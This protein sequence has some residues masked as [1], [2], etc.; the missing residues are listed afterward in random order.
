MSARFYP[1]SQLV[2]STHIAHIC[3]SHR[4]THEPKFAIECNSPITQKTDRMTMNI[5]Y[6]F[7]PVQTIIDP[8]IDTNLQNL[9]IEQLPWED[10]EKLC[11]ALVQLEFRISDCD[12][13]GTKGQSQFGIDIFAKQSNGKYSTYQCK[14]YQEYKLSHLKEAI[15]HFE[16]NKFAKTSE[17]FVIC[18]SCE[19]NKTQIQ[20]EFEKEKIRLDKKSI[21][22]E[23]WDKIQLLK[24]L[25]DQPQIVNDFFGLA[26]VKR[27]NGEL[28]LKSLSKTRKLDAVQVAK[29]RTELYTFYSTIFNTQDPGI[30]IQEIN[31]SSYALQDRFITPD[32]IPYKHSELTDSFLE[33]GNI[34]YSQYNV[35]LDEDEVFFNQNYMYSYNDEDR[36]IPKKRKAKV[37]NEEYKTELRNNIDNALQHPN[38]TI[39]I[40]DPGS[41]KST[42]LRYLVLDILSPNPSLKNISRQCGKLLPVWL[43]FAFLTK[44]L[45]KDD[46]LNIQMLLKMW[47]KSFGKEH[48]YDSVKDA[49]EDDRLFLIIDGIDEWNNISSAQQALDRI[50]TTIQLFNTRIIYSSRPYGFKLMKD[51]FT[52][53][54]IFTLATFSKNQ[55]KEFIKKW[56][57]K[58]QKSLKVSDTDFSVRETQSFLLELDQTNDLSQLAGNPLL[59]SILLIQK[60]RNSV[61]PK[62]R[63]I[64]LKEITEYLINKH[65]LKRKKDAAIVDETNNDIDFT[66]IFCELAFYIQ[67]QS[68]DGVITKDDACKAISNYLVE[69]AGFEK[70]QAKRKGAEFV[71]VGA[72]NFGIIVEKSN[73]EIS[74]THRQFQEYLAAQYL[75]ESDEKIVVEYLI[76]HSSNPVFHQVII[77][78]FG[79]ISIKKVN[80]FTFFFNHVREA[81]CSVFQE[82]YLKLLIYEIALNLSNTPINIS[83]EYFIKIVIEFEY[84]PFLSKKKSFLKILLNALNIGKLQSVVSAFILKYFPNQHKYR[85]YR[86]QTL[87]YVDD[88]T[89]DLIEFNIK[90]MINGSFQIKLDASKSINK[91]IANPDIFKSIKDIIIR[92]NDPEIVGCAFNSLISDKIEIDIINE[93]SGCINLEHP[94]PH[95]FILKHKVF[96]NQHTENDLQTLITISNNLDYHLE[97]EVLSLFI[98]GFSESDK[99]KEEV[100]QSLND[101][102]KGKISSKIAWSLLFHCYSKDEYAIKILAKEISTQEFP[103]SGSMGIRDYWQYIPFY[104]ERKLELVEAIE[105]WIE[106]QFK[107]YPFIETS[108]SFA[109]IYVK[110]E[111]VK[112]YLLQD[113]DKSS[114]SHWLVMALLDGWE[115]NI[116]IKEKLKDYFRKVDTHKTVMAAHYVPRIFTSNCEKEEAIP[117]LKNIL[118]DRKLQFR[119]RALSALI[120]LDKISFEDNLLTEFL[121]ELKTIPNDDFGQYYQAIETIIEHFSTNDKV[122][123]FVVNEL[124]ND[125]MAFGIFVKYYKEEKLIINNLIS[126]SLPL[127][128]ELRHTIIEKFEDSGLINDLVLNCLLSFEQ[129][130]EP[131]LM[132]DASLCLFNYLIKTN[133]EARIIE[134][135]EPLI[136]TRGFDYEIKRN[137]SFAG[138]L[139]TH[140]LTDYFNK[141]DSSIKANEKA[142]PVNLFSYE[143]SRISSQMI[144]LLINE[145]QYL[146]E[147]VGEDFGKIIDNPK[148]LQNVWGFFAKYSDSSSVTYDYIHNYIV[149]NADIIDNHYL[150]N[151]L[152][153]TKPDSNIH[154]NILLRL[155]TGKESGIK[156]YAGKLLGT[157]FKD[158]SE[159]FLKIKDVDDYS[160]YGKIIALCTGWPKEPILRTMFDE[161]VIN[162]YPINDYAGFHLKFLFRSSIHLFDFMLELIQDPQGASHYRNYL[163][164]PLINR[165]KEDADLAM[166][167]KHELLKTKS[168]NI[169]ISFYNLLLNTSWIDDEIREWKISNEKNVNE[170]GYDLISNKSIRFSEILSEYHYS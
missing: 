132:M 69:Y 15:N 89:P 116:E 72:N 65:P 9:P 166:L 81:S 76:T 91:H 133:N 44:H 19:W 95:F 104:F 110:S 108:I 59:L 26:W 56:F 6:L 98:N 148:N 38:R 99:L 139:I 29:Y 57:D 82:E 126:S 25:K 85:D 37:K 21:S 137:I 35:D 160:D 12:I 161:L 162:H 112:N 80:E 45:S 140:H 147:V 155:I 105:N 36:I 154:K 163:F 51:M 48:L 4:L 24:I 153:R 157:I 120:E 14:R 109:C 111:K 142:H 119:V 67:N 88:L 168:N 75:A 127:H 16:Q 158:D 107:K 55:Q 17:K 39:I 144:N 74:F 113:L 31:N 1:S 169:K 11:L 30:P 121:I 102:Q 7:T 96:R 22:L 54:N 141:E 71:E 43:P 125:Q 49:L 47:F 60:L 92:S 78:F 18:T 123:Q 94:I 93:L 58:W 77:T 118:F 70:A 42:L 165:L 13:Y 90:S 124:K 138:F 170:Y 122:K 167:F 106:Q 146:I 130:E 152:S 145:F 84:E 53:I 131:I 23:K 61:L 87:K 86:V 50:E 114:I 149:N 68:N 97:D 62:N 150:V 3:K 101:K 103:F 27:F 73:N 63:V 128:K 28:A 32:V 100:F 151:F 83:S 8:P 64:A 117:I 164:I 20:D 115:E 159:V 46:S 52:D 156:A 5:N 143:L 79:L 10:F 34:E 40:G 134:I 2:K 66:D 41:G 33:N 129:E 135:C 136:F